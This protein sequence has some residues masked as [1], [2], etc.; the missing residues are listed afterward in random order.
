MK[1]RANAKSSINKNIES[2]SKAKQS[3]I[4]Q[5]RSLNLPTDILL[6]EKWTVNEMKEL[7]L[8]LKSNTDVSLFAI[9]G[10]PIEEM[11]AIREI[12]EEYNHLQKEVEREHTAKELDQN[13]E[14][15]T[16]VKEFIS[17]NDEDLTFDENDIIE[18]SFE[19]E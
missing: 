16:N 9:K 3:I 1:K 8:G 15:E 6:E 12:L 19:I 18:E 7:F 10:L 11:R 14:V 4:N 13:S 5:A 17:T 2:L